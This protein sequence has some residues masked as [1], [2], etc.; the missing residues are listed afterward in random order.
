MNHQSS[1][2]DF[3]NHPEPGTGTVPSSSALC[4]QHLM[5]PTINSCRY[6][7]NSQDCAVEESVISLPLFVSRMGQTGTPTRFGLLVVLLA[8]CVSSSIGFQVRLPCQ[9]PVQ[10]YNWKSAFHSRIPSSCRLSASSISATTVTERLGLYDR[11]DRWRFLQRLLDEEAKED[12]VNEILFWVLDG[13]L[14]YP[15]PKFESTTETGSPELTSERRTMVEALLDEY[16]AQRLV[17]ALVGDTGEQERT[18]SKIGPLLPDPVEDED[19]HK[20]VWDTV[21]ELN[22]RESVKINETNGRPEWRAV[23][24]V[25]RVLINYDF[26]TYGLIDAPFK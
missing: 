13:Y 18:L 3:L 7:F 10:S 21:M 12:D 1:F 11:F 25:A 19:A 16:T 8:S 26:L 24:L 14:R 17:P 5:E 6:W 4:L 9:R 23:C 22:G 15:R 20:G 2:Q